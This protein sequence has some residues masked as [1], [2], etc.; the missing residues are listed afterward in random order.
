MM[1]MK[2]RAVVVRG[3]VERE[4]EAELAQ[5]L[6]AEIADRIGRGVP[7]AQA[8]REAAL[9]F[10]RLEAIK[11]DCRDARGVGPWERFRQDARYTLRLL[12]RNRTFSLMALVTLALAIGPT[13]AVFS[14]I[15]GI[16][17]RP[18]QF[19]APERLFHAKDVDLTGPFDTLRSHSR[20][21]EYAA[22]A[23]I[24]GFSTPGREFPERVKGAFVSANFFRVLGA[25]PWLGRTFLEG[26]DGPAASR[27][28]ILSHEF[29][30]RRYDGRPAAIGQNLILDE[31]AYRIVAVMPPGFHD[32]AAA[33]ANFWIPLVIDPSSPGA[34]WGSGGLTVLA[35]LHD[36]ATAAQANAELR[37]W[38]ARMR[39]MFPW[40]MPDA[41]G[42]GTQLTGLQD[43]MVAPVQSRS[44]LLLGAVLLVLL[45]AIV[46]VANLLLGQAASRRYEL[47]LRAS[48]GAT[49]GR[50]ARQLLTEAVILAGIGG[51]LGVSLAYAQL[52]WLK[53]LLPADTPRLA[54]AA[55]DARVLACSAAVALGSGLLFG[56]LP[57]WRVRRQSLSLPDSRA[58]AATHGRC[59]GS[60]LVTAEAAFATVL[61]VGAG[62]LLHSLWNLLR[63]DPGFRVQSMV[64]AELSLDRSAA[65]SI[66]KTLAVYQQ[67]R[68]ALSAYPGVASV[69][70]MNVLPLTREPSY[71]S[72]AIDDHPR[73][74]QDPQ[75]VLWTNFVTP[76]HLD[77]LG[78]RLL[79]GRRF[80]AADAPQAD[81]VAIIGKTMAHRFWPQADP[82]GKRLRPASG[83][84]W[85]T[86]VGVVDDVK[87]YSITGPPDWVDGEVYLPLAQA[88]FVPRT[89]SVIARLETAPGSFERGLP[90][91]VR[92]V[93]ANCAV[94]R[95]A[96]MSTIVDAATAAPRST[97]W[98]VASFALL[99]LALAAAG[100]YGVVSHGVRRRMRELG[101]RMALGASRGAILWLVIG[102]SLRATLLGAATG[103]A[104]SWMLARGIASLLYGITPRD[105]L[106]FALAP[107]ILIAVT[108]LASS[109]PAW[110][111]VR[112]D[113]TRSLREG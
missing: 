40:R 75:F 38:I 95:V 83:N 36:D 39:K 11:E 82:I 23:G 85:R 52:A 61:L 108:I 98:L 103:L 46:N 44:L 80:T 1:F 63:V 88:P 67:L 12:A 60:L 101:V 47:W 45:I 22:H 92:E 68:A 74:P 76:E 111:A 32:P 57:A 37:A 20:Q 104:A 89:I 27:V 55:I 66:E 6:E 90:R 93:C 81:R 21:A 42:A 79:R 35:R 105:P 94:G 62:L 17:L 86:I 96:A 15:D 3:R 9:E 97:T 58:A 8:H 51:A 72:A 7:P 110:R 33:A 31:R 69:A 65:G 100:I 14:L 77:T 84:E 102:S 54:E 53:R 19:P 50:L 43:H 48:L 109:L 78:I 25:S 2:L 24:R 56:L 34:Y 87:N 41:W 29:W 28:A 71:L 73:P 113:P 106:G 13:T 107:V 30:M 18:L 112:S 91:L 5:N 16:L 26:E 99:A 4:M 49:P 10:G 59:T 70:A 64:T